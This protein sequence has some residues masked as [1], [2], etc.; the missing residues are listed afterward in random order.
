MK[1]NWKVRMKNPYFWIGL[2]AVILA[3]VGV[4]PESLT[5]WSILYEQVEQL[6]SN[7]FA[8]GC[9]VV[10]VIGYLNDPTTKGIKD[11]SRALTYKKPQ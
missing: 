10:A 2:L 7:P 4:T 1:I 8:M 11:S 5:S 9:V 6:L 3:A